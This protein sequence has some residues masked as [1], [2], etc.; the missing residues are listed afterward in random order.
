MITA[1]DDTEDDDALE[2]DDEY[3][4]NLFPEPP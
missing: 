3:L 4:E 2:A 1:E